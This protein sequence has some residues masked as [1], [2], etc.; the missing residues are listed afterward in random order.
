MS[1]PVR[2]DV[3][4]WNWRNIRGLVIARGRLVVYQVD[5]PGYRQEIVEH[6]GRHGMTVRA[7]DRSTL[8][9]EL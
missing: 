8:V 5:E 6:A 2:W 4:G 9:L 7:A 3:A 1:G